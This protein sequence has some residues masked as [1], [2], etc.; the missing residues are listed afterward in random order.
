MKPWPT[1]SFTTANTIGVE[2]VARRS[3]ASTGVL[4]PTMTSGA[5]P[6]SSFAYRLIKPRSLAPYR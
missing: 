6:T 5:R 4:F 2:L 1:G 3:A